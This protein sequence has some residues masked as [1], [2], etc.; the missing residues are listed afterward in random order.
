[1]VAGILST[2]KLREMLIDASSGFVVSPLPR[3]EEIKLGAIDLS[4]GSIF[5]IARRASLPLIEADEPQSSR[6]A[7]IEVRVAPGGSIVLQPQQF[8]LACTREY[9]TLPH[10]VGGF[11]QSRSTYGRMGLIAATATYVTAGYKGCPTLEIV[12][13]GEVPV[14]VKPGERICQ[15]V[16]LSADEDPDDLVPSR[17]QCATRPFPSMAIRRH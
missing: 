11:I 10:N 6:A 14:R 3:L 17:Y 15:L 5:L 12:N 13:E 16:A 1:V 4:L 9:I 8:A 2:K 7:F